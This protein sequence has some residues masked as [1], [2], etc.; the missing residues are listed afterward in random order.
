MHATDSSDMVID[1]DVTNSSGRYV[2]GGFATRTYTVEAFR[3]EGPLTKVSGVS[4]TDGQT[5]N[6][7][8]A[9]P[10]GSISGTVK[11]S[12]QAAIEGATLIATKEDRVYIATSDASGN[13]K[14]EFLPAGTY[15]VIVDPEENDYVAGKLDDVIVVGSQEK[16]NQNFTLSQDGKITGTITDSS[17]EPIEGAIVSAIEPDDAENDPTVAFIP[18]KTDADGNYTVRHLRSGTYTILVRAEGY[19]SDSETDVSVTAGQTTSGKNF[20][21]GTSGGTIS[22]T[23]YESDGQTEIEKAMVQCGSEGKSW[24]YT[25]SDSNGDYSLTLLQAGTYEVMAFAEGYEVETLNNI[26]LTGT[27]EN[28]GNDFTLD[29]EE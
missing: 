8:L 7:D 22:G 17:Q 1:V 16:S 27:E 28:S 6:R 25:M 18:T 2:L 21:L 20:S 5:T 13:Y 11:N 10:G 4:V 24:G 26:V 9:A 14:I 15:Q 23:V 3:P 12:S 29:E 19:V